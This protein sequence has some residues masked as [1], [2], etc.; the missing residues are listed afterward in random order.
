TEWIARLKQVGLGFGV[1]NVDI[2]KRNVRQYMND[3]GDGAR[4]EFYLPCPMSNAFSSVTSGG[5]SCGTESGSDQSQGFISAIANSFS[6]VLDGFSSRAGTAA[7]PFQDL[8]AQNTKWDDEKNNSVY[9]ARVI[10]KVGFTG[11]FQHFGTTTIVQRGSIL[12][13]PYVLRR[14][15]DNKE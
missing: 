1:S 6:G 9:T 7:I 8:M 3:V 10:Y 5:G 14:T 4:P 11:F 2:F 13:H 15:D 12:S